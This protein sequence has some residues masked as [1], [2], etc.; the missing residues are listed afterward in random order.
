MTT[1][2]KQLKE[3]LLGPHSTAN[4]KLVAQHIK[5]KQE[6]Q[7]LINLIDK[8]QPYPTPE[9]AAWCL[10]HSL[11]FNKSHHDFIGEQLIKKIGIIERDSLTKNI[12]GVI[13]YTKF[14][15]SITGE[16]TN[17]CLTFLTQ[18]YRSK[19]VLYYSLEIMFEICQREPELFRELDLI[20]QEILPIASDAFKR[21]YVKGKKAL[22]ID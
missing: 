21:K 3:E 12:L 18:P 19:A 9:A 20:V 17:H 11:E 15:E 2:E 13:K 5:N 8:A 22:K 4:T 14:P 1:L 10:R 16:L 7:A 6:I